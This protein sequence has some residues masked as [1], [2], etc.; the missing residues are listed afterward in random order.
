[1][2]RKLMI[3]GFALA[4]ILVLAA[5]LSPRFHFRADLTD[6]HIY[7]LTPYT[8]EVL[9]S[10][11]SEVKVTWYRSGAFAGRIPSMREVEDVLDEYGAASGGFFT[12]S[13]VDPESKNS[14]RTVESLGI[15]PRQI[16][17][18]ENGGPT[19]KDVYSGLLVEHG[20]ESRVIP[21]LSDRTTLEYDLTRFILEMQGT[22]VPDDKNIQVVFGNRKNL[23]RYPYVGP[24]LSY[25]G[26]GVRDVSLP[27]QSLDPAQGLLVIGSA[28]IDPITADAIDGFLDAG[29]N[30][31]F[32]VSGTDI[33]V[34]GNWKADEKRNDNLLRVL[35]HHGIIIESDLVIDESNWKITMPSVDNTKY[36]YIQYPFWV[37][38][39]AGKA[40]RSAPVLNGA[41]T[42]QFYWPSSILL[43]T[44]ADPT[45]DV[46][47]ESSL[48]SLTMEAPFD[49]DP[50][51]NQLS[52]IEES[53]RKAPAKIAVT[54]RA[55]GRILCVADEYFPS[56]MIEYTASDTNNDFLV[57]CV[58]WI[59]GNDRLLDLKREPSVSQSVTAE[60]T[61]AIASYFRSGRIVMLI[62]LP[63]LI[64]FFFVISLM[65]RR[66]KR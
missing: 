15:I 26:I 46:I 20:G 56:D 34:S 52:L 41:G 3:D 44:A 29:G 1:M 53:G 35:A 9:S 40:K 31:V 61:D 24:W 27:A 6:N 38:V 21:F 4:V 33:N 11:E 45:L 22:D 62:V 48:S 28:D 39:N 23:S 64:V 19:L 25:A 18:A 8:H 10:L 32:F 16:E 5:L 36:E 13:I 58:E 7:S 49:T 37:T 54:S 30:A 17:L 14:S 63:A 65:I 43:D 12:C 66:L 57:S 50:F 42:L 59:S 55:K 2:N 47:L 60:E 51:G